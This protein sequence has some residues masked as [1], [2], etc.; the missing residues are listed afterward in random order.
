MKTAFNILPDRTQN[1]PLHLLVVPGNYGI[2]FIWFTKAPCTVKGIAVYNYTAKDLPGEMAAAIDNILRS[3]SVFNN[4]YA[5]VTV[6]YDYKESLLVPESCY[7][8]SASDAM[9]EMVYAS[10]NNSSII[11]EPVKNLPVYNVFA[12]HKKIEAVLSVQFPGATFHHAT[13]MQVNR[14]GSDDKKN[15]YGI[16]F[17]NSIKVIM[18]NGASLQFVQQ[19]NY[20]TPVDAAYHLLNCCK[21]YDFDPTGITLVLSGM[22]DEKSKLYNELYKYFLNIEFDRPAEEIELHDRIKFYPPHFFS[23]LT[24]LASCVS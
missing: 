15:I 4:S 12:V 7:T 14:P 17:H 11:A 10:D 5:S 18:F 20:N 9:L 24:G 8:E 16:F 1:V 3:N 23:H 22:I 6:C 13:S 21:Q 19:F 2:S